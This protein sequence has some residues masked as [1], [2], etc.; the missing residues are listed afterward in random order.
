LVS[1]VIP[2]HNSELTI[3]ETLQSV[4]DQ[5]YTNLEIIVYNNFS[6]D[7]TEEII[8]KFDDP[9]ITY[10]KS[11]KLLTMS[12]SWTSATRLG[13]GDLLLLLC[14]DDVIDKY[15]IETLHKGYLGDPKIVQVM[16]RRKLRTLNG[17]IEINQTIFRPKKEVT[18][19][20]VDV[21][22]KVA[23]SGSNPFGE[24]LVALFNRPFLET[25]L[26]WS[27]NYPAHIDVDMY[28]RMSRLGETL[29]IPEIIGKWRFGS[30]KSSTTRSKDLFVG[31]FKKLVIENYHY[32]NKRLPKLFLTF[33]L[34][35]SYFK[36]TLRHSIVR[37]VSILKL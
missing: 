20:N 34:V 30:T 1:I 37:M 31:E 13:T 26:P 25:C 27:S 12:E 36:K 5:S 35:K 11:N 23:M 21:I 14:S 7:F 4:L 10:H 22:H 17:M 28:L 29:L 9:R 3:K 8:A 2:C 6:N 16:G 15:A 19:I 24:T 18:L 32:A 33:I